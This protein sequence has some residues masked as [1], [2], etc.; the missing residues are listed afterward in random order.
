MAPAKT[1][2]GLTVR[3]AAPEDLGVIDALLARSYP[4][5]LKA[6][7][8][9]SVMVT[10]VPLIAKAQPK[11]VRSGQYFVVEEPC[12]AI[13]AAGGWS[14]AAPGGGAARPGLAHIRHVVT[15]PARTRRGYARS[16]IDR[17][18][19]EAHATGATAVECLSTRT[20]EPFYAALGFNMV[21]PVLV[22]LR[23][24]ITFPALRMF[25]AL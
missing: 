1:G 22:A 18:L 2:A 12:G 23:P 8:P 15:D 10:A 25:R 24:G 17:V 7:Y 9:P 5:L 19:E 13:R 20:A 3:R 21:R 16:L 11:L 14:F 4:A 6:D